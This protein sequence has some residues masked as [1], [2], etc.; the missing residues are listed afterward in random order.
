MFFD[1][2]DLYFVYINNLVHNHLNFD[3]TK[4]VWD[5]LLRGLL[6]FHLL[7]AIKYLK[8]AQ[9]VWKDILIQMRKL[10]C[11]FDIATP[12]TQQISFGNI[13]LYQ[14]FHLLLSFLTSQTTSISPHHLSIVLKWEK[15]LTYLLLILLWKIFRFQDLIDDAHIAFLA[16]HN[17]TPWDRKHM[18]HYVS[19]PP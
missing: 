19:F 11:W 2:F 15:F 17:F 12:Y 6:P 4:G 16:K 10:G 13:D 7:F 8:D 3:L 1:L 14:Q 18:G 5:F 9:L